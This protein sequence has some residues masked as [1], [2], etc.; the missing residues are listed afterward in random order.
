MKGA[1]PP[2]MS[3]NAEAPSTPF[4]KFSCLPTNLPVILAPRR[5]PAVTA[6]KG[7]PAE[8]LAVFTSVGFQPVSPV[9]YSKYANHLKPDVIVALG[10]ISYGPLPGR[11]RASKMA[12][13][14]G[15]W[16]ESILS[17]LEK[18]ADGNTKAAVFA[19]ILPTEVG[20]Q[21]YYFQHLEELAPKCTGLA[22]Y[23][24]A[25]LPALSQFPSME[26]LARL[27]LD[28]ASG[29]H[30]ILNQVEMGMDIFCLPFITAATESGLALTFKFPVSPETEKDEVIEGTSLRPLAVNLADSAF[31]TAVEPLSKGCKCYAC[32]SHHRAYITHLLSAHEML[33]WTL[34]QVHN[35]AVIAD[36][37]T[38]IRHSIAGSTFAQ[39]KA[40]FEKTYASEIGAGGAQK[41]RLRGYH[42]KSEG[43]D[44]KR[45]PPA[46]GALG[47]DNEVA[48]TIQ[49]PAVPEESADE[50]DK[51]GFAENLE[52]KPEKL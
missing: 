9:D 27:S 30:E 15:M 8:G 44:R 45:N 36:F 34:L 50:L 41:P 26:C 11:K 43:G 52:D 12:E 47:N 22:I 16:V 6:P 31:A 7:N 38:G 21:S 2:I 3:C 49:S 28:E 17:N 48:E 29:P 1:T 35:H 13:R 19:P 10:D 39:D 42:A 25:M 18:G 20:G 4:Y 46:W 14:T 5:T 37:F 51:K 40:L 32:T 23:D 24:S 33:A